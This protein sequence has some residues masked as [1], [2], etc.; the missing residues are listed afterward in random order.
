M[1]RL[2]YV[3]VMHSDIEMG[4]AAAWYREAFIT[5]HG[6]AKWA[7]R[8]RQYARIWDEVAQ[9]ID[10]LNLDFRRVR[11][12]QDSLPV[13]GHEALIVR[14]LAAQGSRNHQLLEA[15]MARGAEVMGTESADL[16]IEEYRLMQNGGGGG[17]QGESLLERRDRFIAQRI[18]GTLGA[19][20]T[21]LLF[22]GALHRVDTYL[23]PD[24]RVTL[25]RIRQE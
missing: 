21:A 12:Y 6:E 13:C 17:P 11:L 18:D 1:R 20:E 19:D 3:P 5:R 2:I 15:L 23:P 22:I 25:V 10:G 14:D 7:E 16:L 4:S 9:A 8:D 24:I